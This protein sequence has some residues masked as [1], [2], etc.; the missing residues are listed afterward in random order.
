MERYREFVEVAQ[1]MVVRT[2]PEMPFKFLTP[3]LL[4]F[5]MNSLLMFG[6]KRL[7]YW[8]KYGVR[9]QNCVNLHSMLAAS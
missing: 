6:Y 1:R 7:D 2:V 5:K 3:E 9:G 4:I 8:R